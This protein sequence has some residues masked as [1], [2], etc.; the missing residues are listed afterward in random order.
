MIEGETIWDLR[1]R[2]T[3]GSAFDQDQMGAFLA[4]GADGICEQDEVEA[5]YWYLLAV[6]QGYIDSK[7]NLGT[8]LL[9]GEGGPEDVEKG[10][11]LIEQAAAEGQY[12]AC[13][14]LRDIHEVGGYGKSPSADLSRHWGKEAE[15]IRPIDGA[16][17]PEF[18][19]PLPDFELPG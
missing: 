8:M 9:H 6:K 18:G 12:S 10:M 3:G 5:R 19:A 7:W 17:L 16:D 11:F 2:A 4:T 15:R 13:G 1:E 14:F